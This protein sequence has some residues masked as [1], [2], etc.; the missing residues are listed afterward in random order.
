MISNKMFFESSV[1]G[2]GRINSEIYKVSKQINSM[3]RVSTPADDPVAAA[4]V[5][6]MKQSQERNSQFIL[7]IEDANSALTLSS[8]A[9]RSIGNVITDMKTL[10]VQAGN[11]SLNGG[12]FAALQSQFKGQLEEL[13]SLANTQDAHGN[14]L[15]G[16]TKGT[17]PPFTLEG[18]FPYGSNTRVTYN[19][20]DG[21]KSIYISSDRQIAI[22]DPGSA[23]LGGGSKDRK[24]SSVF[25]TAL[26]LGE[27]VYQGNEGKL[28]EIQGIPESDGGL[29]NT[30][31]TFELKVSDIMP[32][33]LNEHVAKDFNAL[34]D[35][36]G[37]Y[38]NYTKAGVGI[39]LNVL[40]ERRGLENQLDIKFSTSAAEAQRETEQVGVTGQP[41]VLNAQG[42]VKDKTVTFFDNATGVG[43]KFLILPRGLDPTTAKWKVEGDKATVDDSNFKFSLAQQNEYVVWAVPPRVVL[44]DAGSVASQSEPGFQQTGLS[45]KI[46]GEIKTKDPESGQIKYHLPGSEDIENG[47]YKVKNLATDVAF[48]KNQSGVE[49]SLWVKSYQIELQQVL[50]RLDDS[51]VQVT[52]YTAQ[53]GIRQN[54]AT[55]TKELNSDLELI[56]K[57]AISKLVDLDF[58]RASS[59]LIAAQTALQASQLAFSRLSSL[60]LFQYL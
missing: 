55:Q 49:A 54:E 43:G 14:Y 16:G 31:N 15:F 34:K 8:R 51:L 46:G 26:R 2:M 45:M 17:T 25:Y 5:L 13:I 44:S 22:S 27:M 35:A 23:F 56:Q 10:A 53:L 52:Q 9:M 19:G 48:L 37:S 29:N 33:L 58:A 30:R 38:E 39:D 24:L 40:T 50:S 59:E 32:V 11:P 28:S 21:Q 20:D 41:L 4:R 12:D 47:R 42:T 36:L 7:N 3:K 6:S 57:T 18:S 60:G 1:L